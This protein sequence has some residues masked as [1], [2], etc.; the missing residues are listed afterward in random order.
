MI[1]NE[2][3]KKA[4][5]ESRFC[6]NCG[7]NLQKKEGKALGLTSIR[8]GPSLQNSEPQRGS[9]KFRETK[10]RKKDM[11]QELKEVNKQMAAA[12]VRAKEMQAKF[13]ELIF[14][15]KEERAKMAQQYLHLSEERE[16]SERRANEAELALLDIIQRMRQNE[17]MQAE[18]V[19]R[20]VRKASLETMKAVERARKSEERLWKQIEAPKQMMEEKEHT[21]ASNRVLDLELQH[22]RDLDALE[23]MKRA[24][25][26]LK[27]ENETQK[28]VFVREKMEREETVD[29]LE[30]ILS[31]S[32]DQ[33]ESMREEM[34]KL[35]SYKETCEMEAQEMKQK[36]EYM[37]RNYSGALQKAIELEYRLEESK[38]TMESYEEK[39]A[40]M[41]SMVQRS[42]VE[43]KSKI[44]FISKKLSANPNFYNQDLDEKLLVA[45]DIAEFA[46]RKRSEAE[47]KVEQLQEKLWRTERT[48]W[49]IEDRCNK[50]M[51]IMK[52]SWW[53]CIRG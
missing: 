53:K 44:E 48:L 42:R 36:L 25:E 19:D 34:A 11:A 8:D 51:G 26:D 13:C 30:S 22:N 12:K 31:K 27:E 17:A 39:T 47:E 15:V 43:M 52:Q 18:R 5:N 21:K 23:S 40:M 38:R 46:E 3:A 14:A 4:K 1:Y 50:Q 20:I 35:Q 16:E 29:Q 33:M 41:V 49:E 9:Q 6:T 10:C 37:I 45:V 24:I 2:C 7:D 28:K 32:L